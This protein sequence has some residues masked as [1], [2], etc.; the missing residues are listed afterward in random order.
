[1]LGDIGTK[2]RRPL[3]TYVNHQFR[4]RA[5]SE[6]GSALIKSITVPPLK[7]GAKS[8]QQLFVIEATEKAEL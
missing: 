6:A 7:D 1:M 2:E 4:V 5:S 8:N 3:Q